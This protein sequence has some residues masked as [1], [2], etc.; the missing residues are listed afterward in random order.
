VWQWYN[1]PLY[2]TTDNWNTFDTTQPCY[3][4]SYTDYL[5]FHDAIFGHCFFGEGDTMIVAGNHSAGTNSSN[6]IPAGTLARTTNGG[7]RWEHFHLADSMGS[8]Q[9]MT[10]VDHDTIYISGSSYAHTSPH[11]LWSSDRGATW[12]LDTILLDTNFEAHTAASMTMTGD[13][14]PLALFAYDDNVGSA[15]GIYR[16]EWSKSEVS[17]EISLSIGATLYPNPSTSELNF[18][19]AEPFSGVVLCDLLGRIMLREA[20]DDKGTLDVSSLPRGVYR[21]MIE[22]RGAWRPVGK[23]ALQ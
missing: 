1:G 16:G 22:Q 9:T 19:F 4:T 6:A 2:T 21:V 3:D 17:S 13:G 7:R 23:V 18:R 10:G 14:Y 15:T 12:L 20:S 8:L 5:G 11:L